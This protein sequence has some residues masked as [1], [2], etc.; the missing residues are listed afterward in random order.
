M[1]KTLENLWIK[2]AGN[3]CFGKASFNK[4]KNKWI[5]SKKEVLAVLKILEDGQESDAK[6]LRMTKTLE[7]F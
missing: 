5:K 3:E 7:Y 4:G 2:T 1:T 6:P